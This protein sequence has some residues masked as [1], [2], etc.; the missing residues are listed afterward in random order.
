MADLDLL[1]FPESMLESDDESEGAPLKGRTT[2]K[3]HRRTLSKRGGK[4]STGFGNGRPVSKAEQKQ[5]E[6]QEAMVASTS[7]GSMLDM[8]ATSE[9]KPDSSHGVVLPDFMLGLAH[10]TQLVDPRGSSS[11]ARVKVKS[12]EIVKTEQLAGSGGPASGAEVE[13]ED[14]DWDD[15][16]AES[17]DFTDDNPPAWKRSRNNAT[18]PMSQSRGHLVS[19][20]QVLLCAICSQTSKEVRHAVVVAVVV[21]VLKNI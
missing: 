18:A 9:E 10:T 1:D 17:R 16:P 15:V 6:V 3:G 20:I 7:A 12:A 2:K 21:V 5:T 19:L 11:S 13:G 4:A 8:F 14:D